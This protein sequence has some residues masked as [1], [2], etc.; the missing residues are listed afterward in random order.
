MA[1]DATGTPTSPDNIPTYAT[2]ADAPSGK[3]FN[4][5]MAAIQTALSGRWLKS[6]FTTTGDIAYAS[7][8]STPTRLGIGSTGNVLTVA[9]GVPTWA[10]PAAVGAMT[11]IFDYTVTGSVAAT[12]DSNT[13]LGGNIPQTF[14][15]LQ[16]KI[17]SRGDTAAA[18]TSLLCQFNGDSTAANYNF[19][20]LLGNGSTVNAVEGVGTVAGAYLGATA[21]A[22]ASA[23][24]ASSKDVDFFNYTGTT[25][26]KQ[27]LTKSA[28]FEGVTSGTFQ[29]ELYA[30]SWRSTAAITRL[31]FSL[32][33]GNFSI[34]TRV[35]LYGL[36]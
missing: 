28:D 24:T 35:T 30:S 23:G 15:H 2:S 6:L 13:I 32:G 21:A 3:G 9:G 22:S 34:G 12:I 29:A 5:A 4:A 25:F 36:S 17:Q 18:A 27:T 10:A 7:A 19:Q 26:H 1:V 8:A 11:Q 20:R 14:K 33:A 31:V 16:A